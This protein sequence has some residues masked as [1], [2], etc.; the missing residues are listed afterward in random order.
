[1]AEHNLEA[2]AFPTL[3]EAQVARLGCFAGVQPKKFRAGEALFRCGDR[4]SKFF[5]VKSG[6]IEI[7]DETG[8]K[9]KTIRT[10]GPGQFTGDVGH[11]TG[12]PSCD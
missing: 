2:I 4:D 5:V 7:I 12:D 6:E 8:E 1:M 10:V 11:L 9:P 3:G